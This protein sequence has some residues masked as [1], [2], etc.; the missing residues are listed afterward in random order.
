[1]SEEDIVGEVNSGDFKYFIANEMLVAGVLE[2]EEEKLKFIVI[3]AQGYPTGM[4][5]SL[6]KDTL[7][8]EVEKGLSVLLYS[9]EDALNFDMEKHFNFLKED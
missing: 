7:D 5:G 3:K 1:M 8:K 4:A 9:Y 2:E 6:L